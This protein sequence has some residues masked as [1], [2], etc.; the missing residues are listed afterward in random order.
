MAV[1]VSN[2][3]G[4]CKRGTAMSVGSIR[5][6]SRREIG[7]MYCLLSRPTH[8]RSGEIGD[9]RLERA[10]WQSRQTGRQA[11]SRQADRRRMSCAGARSRTSGE[12]SEGH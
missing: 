11:D 4:A 6:V 10:G 12:A 8:A 3:A 7:I 9:W 5:V 2:G 1:S